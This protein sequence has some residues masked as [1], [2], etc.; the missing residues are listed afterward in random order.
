MTIQKEKSTAMIEA[1]AKIKEAI[2]I[3]G[4]EAKKDESAR[5]IIANLSV[6]L[7]DIKS[8]K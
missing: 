1:S 2:D 7:L 5:D 3:L 8:R 6:V 4:A